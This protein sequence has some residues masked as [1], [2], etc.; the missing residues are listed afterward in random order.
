MN[1]D[2][3]AIVF[4]FEGLREVHGGKELC[5]VDEGGVGDEEIELDGF[6]IGD[7]G[8]VTDGRGAGGEAVG[9]SIARGRIDFFRNNGEDGVSGDAGAAVIDNNSVVEGLRGIGIAIVGEDEF[10]ISAEGEVDI[11]ESHAWANAV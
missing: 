1:P 2:G 11:D 10:L 8:W 7:S 9:D 5:G 3:G 6:S 4:D